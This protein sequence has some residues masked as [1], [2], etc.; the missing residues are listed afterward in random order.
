MPLRL[1]RPRWVLVVALGLASLATGCGADNPG[2]PRTPAE[3]LSAPNLGGVHVYCVEQE[4]VLVTEC[5]VMLEA[6]GEPTLPE[7]REWWL[8]AAHAL[9]QAGEFN[10]KGSRWR[11]GSVFVYRPASDGKVRYGWRCPGDRVRTAQ[12]AAKLMLERT[13]G[14]PRGYQTLTSARR[15]GCSFG[16]YP[17]PW[18]D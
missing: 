10:Y 9:H 15:H 1:K 14:A 5:D 17:A 6:K 12:V 4:A 16:P 3:R 18:N 13:P 8:R 7:L 2:E 11:F